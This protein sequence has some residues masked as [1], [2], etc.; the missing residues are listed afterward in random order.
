MLCA[1]LEASAGNHGIA[2][3][4]GIPIAHAITPI[5]TIC[6]TGRLR[7][8]VSVSGALVH[9]SAPHPMHSG[10]RMASGTRRQFGGDETGVTRRRDWVPPGTRPG[11]R[12]R[13]D[14]VTPGTEAGA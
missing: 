9:H 4:T 1:W 5:A 10:R 6:R 11:L 13:R 7:T 8:L 12:R 2:S 3:A 14:R